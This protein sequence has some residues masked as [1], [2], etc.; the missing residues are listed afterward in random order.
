MSGGA[1]DRLP[2]VPP[3]PPGGFV[4]VA[5]APEP[6]T[7]EAAAGAV[8]RPAEERGADGVG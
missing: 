4:D 1:A 7:P 6:T 8:R 5:T 3:P 2:Y